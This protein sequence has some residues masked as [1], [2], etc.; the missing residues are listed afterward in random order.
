MW[1]RPYGTDCFHLSNSQI[2]YAGP[3]T[4]YRHRAHDE[5]SRPARARASGWSPRRAPGFRARPPSPSRLGLGRYGAM[6]AA[7]R[8]APAPPR[9]PLAPMQGNARDRI[10]CRP[11][12]TTPRSTNYA[13]HSY[14]GY[15]RRQGER[16]RRRRLAGALLALALARGG[17]LNVLTA[18]LRQ[19]G[20]A[21]REC[22]PSRRDGAK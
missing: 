9:V 13:H 20:L 14:N 4:L 12:L 15:T 17:W 11:P 8:R 10:T 18:D 16:E 22:G 5:R 6:R 19:R 3:R 21:R 1:S 7:D 2:I